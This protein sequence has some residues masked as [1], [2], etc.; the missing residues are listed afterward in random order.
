MKLARP[1]SALKEN[2]MTWVDDFPPNAAKLVGLAEVLG[3]VGLI[4]PAATGIAPIL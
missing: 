2:G 3:A 1:T 4:V